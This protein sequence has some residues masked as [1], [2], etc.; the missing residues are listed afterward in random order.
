M[1]YA[2][3]ASGPFHHGTRADLAIGDLLAHGFGSNFAERAGAYLFLDH[4]RRGDL[5]LR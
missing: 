3:H 1:T 2:I 4:A 5:G